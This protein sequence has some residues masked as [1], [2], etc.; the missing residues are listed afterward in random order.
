MV[1]YGGIRALK[2]NNY[3]LLLGF[4]TISQLGYIAIGV[5]SGSKYGYI[6]AIFHIIAH[7]LAKTTLFIGSANFN[8]EYLSDY[9]NKFR[10]VLKRQKLNSIITTVCFVTLMGFPLL[11]GYNSKYLIKY[12]F[13]GRVLFSSLFHLTS[14]ITYLYGIRFLWVLYFKDKKIKW[15]NIFCLQNCKK[16]F[17]EQETK[18]NHPLKISNKIS[19]IIP[20]IFII[21]LGIFPNSLLTIINKKTYNFHLINGL[22]LNLI[23]LFIASR[24]FFVDQFIVYNFIQDN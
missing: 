24:L 20:V 17:I 23:Y 15:R 11:A 12:G 13:E 5:G 1:F 10:S 3:K 14:I 2:A 16:I 21:I 9:I 22:I 4:S 8:K 7:A 18:G 19:L 6:G